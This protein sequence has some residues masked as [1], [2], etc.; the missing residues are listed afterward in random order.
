MRGRSAPPQAATAARRAHGSH[1]QGGG[2]ATPGLAATERHELGGLKRQNRATRSPGGW[3]REI[4]VCT[5]RAP[6]KGSA[7]REAASPGSRGLCGTRGSRLHRASPVCACAR[8]SPRVRPAPT[9]PSCIR[10]P[11]TR[12]QGPLERPR[13][14]LVTSAETA[15]PLRSCSQAQGLGLQYGPGGTPCALSGVTVRCPD[16]V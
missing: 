16:A 1:L 9:R 3:K 6:T 8:P 11:V 4:K 14:N 2:R 15:S 12:G 7:G 13:F 10:T 5:G